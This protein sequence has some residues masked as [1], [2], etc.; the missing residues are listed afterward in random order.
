MLRTLLTCPHAEIYGLRLWA[1]ATEQRRW[2]WGRGELVPA[3]LAATCEYQGEPTAFVG[4]LRTAGWL[5]VHADGSLEVAGYIGMNRKTVS[6]W[7]LGNRPKKANGEANGQANGEANGQAK[8]EANGQANGEANGQANGEANGQA[9]G[10]AN[11]QANGEANGQANGEA[12]TPTPNVP[13]HTPPL[14]P[15]PDSDPQLTLSPMLP[16]VDGEKATRRQAFRVPTVAEVAA[17]CAERENGVDAEAFV[18]HYQAKGWVV[19]KSPMRDWR[20]AVITWER[21]SDRR[22][23]VRADEKKNY[24]P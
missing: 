11:G 14:I 7:E 3:A 12:N 10:E 20:A 8:G 13:P 2:I 5:T 4:A 16:G 17:Y 15:V 21:G 1:Y 6:N 19:G 22:V 24:R 23:E 9:N 18:A